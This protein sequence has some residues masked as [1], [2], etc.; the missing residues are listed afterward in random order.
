M[1]PKLIIPEHEQVK[2]YLGIHFDNFS[3]TSNP[4]FRDC[5]IYF[6]IMT[7][8]DFDNLGNYRRRPFK[9]I[10]YIDGLLNKTRLTGIG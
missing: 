8:D 1:G 7:H 10:G 9:I 5:M 6:T 4:E 3:P 2:A